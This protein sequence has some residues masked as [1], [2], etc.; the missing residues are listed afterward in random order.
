MIQSMNPEIIVLKYKINLK[1]EKGFSLGSLGNMQQT[2]QEYK[3]VI[4]K[5]VI[6]SDDVAKRKTEGWTI[7]SKEIEELI[8]SDHHH[9]PS[10]FK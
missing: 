9:H 4:R 3:Y 5:T 2:T 8:T 1:S 6:N 10:K 7:R